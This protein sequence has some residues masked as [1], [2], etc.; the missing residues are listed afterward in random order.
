M[1]KVN[2]MNVMRDRLSQ[3][4][5]IFLKICAAWIVI[6]F[7]WSF[8]GSTEAQV[9]SNNP[10]SIADII[11]VVKY[12]PVGLGILMVIMASFKLITAEYDED[13]KKS[14]ITMLF[15]GAISILMFGVFNI[16]I[17]DANMFPNP[18][19]QTSQSRPKTIEENV[20]LFRLYWANLKIMLGV[21]FVALLKIAVIMEILIVLFAWY[22][23][24]RLKNLEYLAK[25]YIKEFQRY[26]GNIDKLKIY[27][28]DVW[29]DPKDMGRNLAKYFV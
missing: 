1:I 12:I 7:L 9:V 27:K 5:L 14:A 4:V 15:F 16:V 22:E 6:C 23:I 29:V 17:G 3:G 19:P 8:K 13:K 10:A 18:F 24:A 2:D 26:K 20:F 25:R 11:N 21:G 28:A